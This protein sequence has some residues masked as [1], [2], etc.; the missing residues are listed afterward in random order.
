MDSFKTWHN[1]LKPS[2]HE[3]GHCECTVLHNNGI[4]Y[5]I[6]LK[7]CFEP[8]FIRY[9]THYYKISN[10]NKSKRGGNGIIWQDSA[11]VTLSSQS[12]VSQDSV[13]K[14]N[15]SSSGFLRVSF[16][17]LLL[18]REFPFLCLQSVFQ[19]RSLSQYELSQSELHNS[20]LSF[21]AYLAHIP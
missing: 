2:L 4:L 6:G 21:Y 12:T 11:A 5:A 8:K 20:F 16:I 14:N 15:L 9:E 7:A 10:E 17:A 19:C 3:Y 13:F 1:A 18:H